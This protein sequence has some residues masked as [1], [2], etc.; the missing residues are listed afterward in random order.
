MINLKFKMCSIEIKRF[1]YT[2]GTTDFFPSH[3]CRPRHHGPNQGSSRLRTW[4]LDH[5]RTETCSGPL[6]ERSIPPYKISTP[7][8]VPTLL[9]L[10]TI[11]EQKSYCCK[12]NCGDF[13]VFNQYQDSIQ[14]WIFLSRYQFNSNQ[15]NFVSLI[16]TST[17]Y[18][19]NFWLP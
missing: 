3:C 10:H 2:E 4:E 14:F 6:T 9:G 11:K 17:W 8:T 13:Y 18:F 12:F 19:Q 1:T 5:R 7:A 16:F 15:F